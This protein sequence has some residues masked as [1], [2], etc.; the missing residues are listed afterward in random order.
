MK[1]ISMGLLVSSVLILARG[2]ALIAQGP[3]TAPRARAHDPEQHARPS[4]GPWRRS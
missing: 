2:G 4:A 3:G 1:T